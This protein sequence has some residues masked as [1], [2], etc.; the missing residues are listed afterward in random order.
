MSTSTVITIF[1][2]HSE[3]CKY[4]GDEFCK[5]CQCKKHF[6]WTLHGVQHRRRA[7]TRSWPE[8]EENKRRLEDQ[9]AGRKP[10]VGPESEERLLSKA[11][12]TFHANK[13]AQG[14]KPRV[15]A[16]YTRELKRLQNYSEAR[17][18]YTVRQALDIDN[19]IGLRGTWSG[20]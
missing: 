9:L 2:R 18:L 15:R 3:D 16:M 13:E 14:I 8:A 1:V 17:G 6:R 11:I 20:V 19:L 10:E 4:K 12:E 5:R 7:G